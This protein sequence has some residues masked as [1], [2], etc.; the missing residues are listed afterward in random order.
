MWVSNWIESV[1]NTSKFHWFCKFIRRREN[2]I[3]LSVNRDIIGRRV[4]AGLQIEIT[5]TTKQANFAL[6][7]PTFW[8]ICYGSLFLRPNQTHIYM[9]MHSRGVF[10]AHMRA[11]C[12]RFKLFLG[13]KVD[14][15]SDK[16]KEE[17]KCQR[18]FLL[19]D[20]TKLRCER[21]EQ[22]ETWSELNK[23]L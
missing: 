6:S 20:M 13:V 4:E 12:E 2:F 17:N 3:A 16:K 15:A 10:F 7:M 5:R 11:V 8:S 9:Y 18:T 14:S 21:E 19:S 1:N 22:Q 23:S